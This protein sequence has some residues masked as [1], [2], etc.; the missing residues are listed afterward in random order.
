MTSTEDPTALWITVII[1]TLGIPVAMGRVVDIWMTQ[2]NKITLQNRL[3]S[4]IGEIEDVKVPDLPSACAGWLLRYVYKIVFPLRLHWKLFLYAGLF[5]MLLTLSVWLVGRSVDESSGG[6]RFISN[7]SPW[8]KTLSFLISLP[9]NA[10]FDFLTVYITI[11]IVEK[12]RNT[13]KIFI[14]AYIVADLVIAFWFALVVGT[15]AVSSLDWHTSG[16]PRVFHW[17]NVTFHCIIN[18]SPIYESSAITWLGLLF[19]LTTFIPTMIYLLTMLALSIAHYSLLLVHFFIRQFMQNIIQQEP[20][21]VAPGTL[22]GTAFVIPISL[23]HLGHALV[24]VF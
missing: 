8:E 9:L 6:T 11:L 5:S 1:A 20:K 10:I 13:H 7:L 2:G 22:V 18:L 14:G 17:L 19:S 24:G 12:I 15:I 16:N 3:R 23:L 4:C 21:D